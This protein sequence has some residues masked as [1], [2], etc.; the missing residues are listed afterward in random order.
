[1]RKYVTIEFLVNGKWT[2]KKFSYPTHW[3]GNT[4]SRRLQ[5]MMQIGK[6][7]LNASDVRLA[8]GIES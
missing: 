3:D 6:R 1:M 2:R 4:L 5:N 8:K 7:E